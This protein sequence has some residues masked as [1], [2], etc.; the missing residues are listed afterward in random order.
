MLSLMQTRKITLIVKSIRSVSERMALCG[1]EGE[2]EKKK[3]KVS[4]TVV[5]LCMRDL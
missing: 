3:K 5:P 2:E 4:E 1:E